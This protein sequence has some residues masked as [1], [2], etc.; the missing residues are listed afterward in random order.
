ML[1]NYT[2]IDAKIYVKN[3]SINYKILLIKLYRFIVFFK[4]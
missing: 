1:K 4:N 2:K 3:G